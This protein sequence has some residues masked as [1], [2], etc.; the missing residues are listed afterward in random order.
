[1]YANPG[2]Y[3][4]LSDI[5]EVPIEE[6]DNFDEESEEQEIGKPIT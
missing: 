3:D 2:E 1:M 4:I 5:R 6:D